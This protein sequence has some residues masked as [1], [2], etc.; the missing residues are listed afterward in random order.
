MT[1]AVVHCG[2]PRQRPHISISRDISI[3]VRPR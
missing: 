2:F 1:N 3:L